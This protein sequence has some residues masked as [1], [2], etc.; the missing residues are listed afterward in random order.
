MPTADTYPHPIG[1]LHC[2]VQHNCFTHEKRSLW[3]IKASIMGA[4]RP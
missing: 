3:L 1:L 4:E 2:M